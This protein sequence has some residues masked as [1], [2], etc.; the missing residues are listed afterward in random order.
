MSKIH[1]SKSFRE[2]NAHIHG[3]DP[4]SHPERVAM[5]VAGNPNVRKV[6]ASGNY[7][8]PSYRK[9]GRVTPESH[10]SDHH[11]YRGSK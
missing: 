7:N 5:T 4:G 11:N 8:Q 6:A 1:N 2:L 3:I 9:G 10:F